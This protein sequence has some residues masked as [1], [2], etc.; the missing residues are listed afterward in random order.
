[1][2]GGLRVV[3]MH[4]E[5]GSEIDAKTH[6]PLIEKL[7]RGWRNTMSR[8]SHRPFTELTRSVGRRRPCIFG[9]ARCESFKCGLT[10]T[11]IEL[12]EAL[13]KSEDAEI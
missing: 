4:F 3:I 5:L 8:A 6:F 10:T 1:M 2:T 13:Q 9:S 12:E 7:V 11:K